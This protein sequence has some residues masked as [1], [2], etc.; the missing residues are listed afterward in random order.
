[1]YDDGST[2]RRAAF[3]ASYLIIDGISGMMGS[4][5]VTPSLLSLDKFIDFVN[6]NII[7]IIDITRTEYMRIHADR[8]RG[9]IDEPTH[10]V[11]VALKILALKK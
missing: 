3:P 6:I 10:Q 4:C 9:L 5:R 7:D 11:A 1:M 2:R 8:N